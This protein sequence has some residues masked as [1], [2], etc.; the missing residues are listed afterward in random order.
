MPLDDET[1]YDSRQSHRNATK[2]KTLNRMM[3]HTPPNLREHGITGD[4][5]HDHC[6]EE[7]HVEDQKDS[8]HDIEN[9]LMT[10]IE[11]EAMEQRDVNADA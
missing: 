6:D 3:D 1:I 11:R 8:R 4:G 5:H 7:R 9:E 10:S 2:E